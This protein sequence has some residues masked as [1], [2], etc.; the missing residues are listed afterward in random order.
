MTTSDALR[1]MTKHALV[2]ASVGI[3]SACAHTSDTP[4]SSSSV[5]APTA[6]AP[7]IVSPTLLD[8]GNYPTTPRPPLGNAG[9][10]EAGVAADARRMA[11]FVIG[12]WDVD[13][14]L[15]NP[16]LNAYYILTNPLLLAQ[17]GPEAIAAAAQEHGFVNGFASARNADQA[18]LVNAVLRFPDPAAATAA[19][20]AMA[21]AAAASPIGGTRP[22]H[23][24]I[25]GHPEAAA[26][27]YP[28]TP[29]GS[30]HPWSV[31]RSFSPH[32][33][34]VFMQL[35]QHSGGLDAATG[36][37]ATAIDTQGPA[38]DGFTPADMSAFAEVPLD[39]TGLLSRTVPLTGDI[40]PSKNAVYPAKGAMHF[41]TD[42]VSSKTLFSDT[43]VSAVAMGKAN[44]Y[45][46]REPLT[47]LMIT[48]GFNTEVL[49]EGAKPADPVPALPESH[50]AAREKSFYCVAPAGKYAIEANGVALP[51]VQQLVAAQYVLLTAK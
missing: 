26:V 40:T 43:G 18:V 3:L 5:A 27:S 21:G 44:V 37:V 38:I 41:Q 23:T 47:A 8:V 19:A 12:P 10:T 14:T 15:I 46:A 42:P 13:K 39:P 29:H 45:Q 4:V 16:Y 17:L 36:L 49:S 2:I 34:F 31:V 24:P 1:R 7:P 48:N 25:P 9:S 35:A 50:C 6:S 30:D 32:G 28:F 22:E 51:D 20:T 33:T 11:E